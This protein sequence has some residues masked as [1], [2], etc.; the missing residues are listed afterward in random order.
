MKSKR[1]KSNTMLMGAGIFLAV[2]VLISILFGTSVL[3]RAIKSG[4]SDTVTQVT[5]WKHW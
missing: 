4:P 3:S 2:Y 1:K 5:V